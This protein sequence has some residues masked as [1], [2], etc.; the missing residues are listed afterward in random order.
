M[1]VAVATN[2]FMTTEE[3][4]ALPEDGKDRWLIRGRLWENEMTKRNRYHG[5]IMIQIGHLLA[6]WNEK[7]PEP[8]G[9]VA[10]GEVGSR[11]KRNPD[12]TV[13]IDVAYFGPEVAL[14]EP[15]G[16]TVFDGPP[17]LAVEINSPTNTIDEINEKV[18]DY[19]DCGVKLVWVVEPKF[20]TVTEYK[21]G[22]EPR[23]Y[24][25]ADTISADPHLPGFA[26]PVA[27]F[28]R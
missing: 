23:M 2:R 3:L 26:C 27:E 19:L 6:S 13:G 28:F 4:L 20:K 25:R 18:Q 8:R 22:A 14:L 9:V 21:P 16:T 5:Q 10:G 17:V 12:S 24:T 11:L 15:S 7:Q 1:S